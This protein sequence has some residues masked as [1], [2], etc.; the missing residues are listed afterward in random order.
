MQLD[1]ATKSHRDVA[2]FLTDDNSKGIRFLANTHGG[3]MAQ[4]KFF[5]HIQVV[6]NREDTTS[7]C[8]SLVR[9][10][11]STVVKRR[12]LEKDVFDK[13]LGDL[14]IDEFTRTDKV[15]E[16]QG[17]L[18][19]NESADLL[20]GHRETGHDDGY[21]ILARMYLFLL[22]AEE[23]YNGADTLVSADAIKELTDLI[24]EENQQSDG[25]DADNAVEKGA[26]KSH[27][28]DLGDEEPKN[29]EHQHAKEDIQRTRFLHQTVAVIKQESYQKDVYEIFYGQREEHEGYLRFDDRRSAI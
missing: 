22:S 24:L 18:H 27:L 13:T 21:D 10:D 7:S 25:T 9:N 16:R 4:A 15:I 3:T 28:K 1:I 17:A 19:D 20:F 2:R 8:D 14:G 12:V 26:E 6:G 29:D 11:H 23:A 5:G